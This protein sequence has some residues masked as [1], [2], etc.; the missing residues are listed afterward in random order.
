MRKICILLLIVFPLGFYLA[1]S[2][3]AEKIDLRLD[4]EIGIA[5]INKDMLLII[6]E[7]DATLLAL[8]KGSTANLNKF[9][10]RNL[11]IMTLKSNLINIKGAIKIMLENDYEIG[12]VEYSLN[13][14]LIHITYED[15]NMCIYT[16]KGD[17]ISDCQFIYFYNT[18]VSNLT[19]T[20]YNEIVLYH[21]KTPLS[22]SILEKV[23]EQAID[24]YPL[25]DDEITIIKLSDED[26]DFIVINNE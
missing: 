13:D 10:Y 8:G 2:T 21:Y 23:Y 11:N 12:N 14:G 16:G 26:Y 18:N 24:T 3:A 22:N 5:F 19:F 20:D 15:T 1:H 17:N 25:R 6:G 7:D 9:Y 4:N